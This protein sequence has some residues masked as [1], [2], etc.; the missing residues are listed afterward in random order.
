M[1]K[2][3]SRLFVFIAV[4][5][6]LLAL[7]AYSQI[8]QIDYIGFGWETGGF[9]AS[10]VGDELSF[11]GIVDYLDPGFEV[12]LVD[13]QMTF[14]VYGLLSQGEIDMGYWTMI[15]YSGGYLEIYQDSNHNGDFGINPP[16]ATSP[17]SFVDGELFF[18]G[19]FT[20]FVLF[21]TPDGNGS[22]EGNLNGINGSMLESSCEDCVYLWG[23]AF[24]WAASAQ[25]IE[26]YDLQID[27][28]LDVDA[29]V[30]S[31]PTTWGS[32]KALYND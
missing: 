23:G 6:A 11:T 13:Y 15:N 10:E 22:F 14:H 19:E 2:S 31:E 20:D 21:F 7:P 27:G 29:A 5:I 24:T 9:P 1:T 4:F 8:Q 17:N 30:A 25:L 16:N 28:A 32:V 3:L 12:D 26:G 18:A